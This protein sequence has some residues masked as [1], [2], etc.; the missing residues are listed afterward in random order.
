MGAMIPAALI[1]FAGTVVLFFGVRAERGRRRL[2]SR[3]RQWPSITGRV[4]ESGTTQVNDGDST[5]YKARIRYEYLV[6]DQQYIG[7]RI[8]IRGAESIFRNKINSIVERYPVGASVEVFYDP[9]QPQ[10]AVLEHAPS[11]KQG[12][13]SSAVTGLILLVSGLLPLSGLLGTDYA[14]GAIDKISEQVTIGTNDKVAYRGEAKAQDARALGEALKAKGYFQGH[15]ASVYL[16]KGKDGA[17]VSFEVKEGAW[18]DARLVTA[19][20]RLGREIAP[21][22]AVY[23]LKLELGYMTDRSSDDPSGTYQAMKTLVIN[24]P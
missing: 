18:D 19:F 12:L 3:S 17:F 24:A 8:S 23:P 20:E 14:R 16:R 7:D 10:M 4:V 22:V 9:Q 21:A 1:S 2:E 11:S 5:T 13:I 6:G 15:G